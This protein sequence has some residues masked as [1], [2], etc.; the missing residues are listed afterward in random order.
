MGVSTRSVLR[1]RRSCLS[2]RG[3]R[4][5]NL[6]C[7]SAHRGISRF[8]VWSFGPSRNDADSKHGEPAH[9]YLATGR[10]VKAARL[11]ARRRARWSRPMD[12]TGRPDRRRRE[13]GLSTR[14]GGPRGGGA[15]QKRQTAFG[16]P[17]PAPAPISPSPWDLATVFPA[18]V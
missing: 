6:R 9:A 13:G 11:F 10:L 4:S 3:A 18:S 12:R 16:G 7:A 2:F 14:Y 8:R 5:A 17:R 1:D 15:A